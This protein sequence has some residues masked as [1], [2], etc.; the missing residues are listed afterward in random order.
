[1]GSGGVP[2]WL[3]RAFWSW[4]GRLVWDAGRGAG[5]TRGASVEAVV[6]A[7]APR[8]R[9]SGERVLDAGCGTGDHVLALA[10]A[11]FVAV[12]VDFAEGM[13]APARAKAAAA[14]S[15]AVFVNA[16]L[17]ARLPFEDGEFDHVVSVSSLQAVA[18]PSFT[19]GELRR[20]LKPGG[21]LLLVHYP[22]PALHA[23]PLGRE[24]RVRAGRLRDPSPA[25]V[26]F[27][28]A[29]AWAERRGGSRYWSADEIRT[30]LRA[31]GYEI[32]SVIEGEGAPIVAL[33]ERS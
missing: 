32:A 13:L 4:G 31:A 1:M 20:V 29:K 30:M 27:V 12:G 15:D 18:D 5:G 2:A 19:L 33:A 28:T 7:L 21:T 16:T 24:V 9:A 23:L 6:A 22:R 11:G 3:R 25:Q 8:R 10:R 17:D 14:G 26:A